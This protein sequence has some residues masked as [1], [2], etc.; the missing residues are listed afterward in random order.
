MASL[1]TRRM[2]SMILCRHNDRWYL[3][4]RASGQS[5]GCALRVG[6]SMSRDAGFRDV[7]NRDLS[8]Q[9]HSLDDITFYPQISYKG[10]R[11]YPWSGWHPDSAEP[12][13]HV[14]AGSFQAYP[15][16]PPERVEARRQELLAKGWHDGGY[17]DGVYGYLHVDDLE[18]IEG[19]PPTGSF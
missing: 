3:A 13:L 18:K 8:M 14:M 2:W 5:Q 16:E 11:V 7:G 17:R 9:L 6:R 19:P 10:L 12:V 4:Q 1:P 15:G